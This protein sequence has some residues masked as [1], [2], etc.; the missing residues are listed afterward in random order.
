VAFPLFLLSVGVFFLALALHYL[1]TGRV[2]LPYGQTAPRPSVFYWIVV[3]SYMLLSALH[4]FA[5]IFVLSRGA[6]T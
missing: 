4:L 2:T 6:A 5:F 1:R 3:V